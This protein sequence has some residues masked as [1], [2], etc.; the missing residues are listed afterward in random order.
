MPP[1]GTGQ[2]VLYRT[3]DGQTRVSCRFEDDS[4]WLTQA[5]MADLFQSTPQNVTLHIGAIYQERE[6]LEEATCKEYLQVRQEGTRKVTRHLK[7]YNLNMILAGWISR[8]LAAWN[9]IPPVGHGAA[10]RV[11]GQG[12]GH[13]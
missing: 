2:L 8:P 12:L 9:P 10:G 3:E 4:V 5:A 11:S 6:L 1:Q 7:H 13:G